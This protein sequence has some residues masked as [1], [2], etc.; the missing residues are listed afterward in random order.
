MVLPAAASTATTSTTTA[1]AA[2]T[3]STALAGASF[4]DGHGAA[5][6]LLQIDRLDCRL[7]LF[8]IGHFH[9][10]KTTRSACFAVHNDVHG[11]DLAMGLERLSNVIFRC[12]IRKVAYIDIHSK[13]SQRKRKRNKAGNSAYDDLTKYEIPEPTTVSNFLGE[14]NPGPAS[15]A[16]ACHPRRGLPRLADG[17]LRG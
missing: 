5:G 17:R 7:A 3:S 8:L 13:I 9:E 12:V 14:V 16:T 1:T 10:R 2:A 15:G 11:R 6:D 4:V